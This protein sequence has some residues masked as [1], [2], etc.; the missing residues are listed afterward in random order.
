MRNLWAGMKRLFAPGGIVR[1]EHPRNPSDRWLLSLFGAADTAAG[2]LVREDNALGLSAVYACLK[3]LAENV[4]SLPLILYRKTGDR[5]KERAADEPLYA[6]L[7]DA[8]NPEMT[9]MNFR[10]ALMYHCAFRGNGYAMVERDQLMRVK[11]LWPLS[12]DRV[13]PYR[14]A[15]K[16]L[17]YEVS[18]SSGE[19]VDL[20]PEFMLHVRT[21]SKDGLTGIAPIDALREPLAAGIAMQEY[22]ARFFSNDARASVVLEHPGQLSDDAHKRLKDSWEASHKGV[23]KAH[24]IG[25][26]EEGMKAAQISLKPEESQFFESRKF[27]VSEIARIWNIPPHLLGE[28]DKGMSYASVEQMNLSFVV[29]TLRPWLVRWEQAIKSQL[30]LGAGPLYAE[31]LVDGLLRGDI[32]TRY[33]A[34]QIGRLNG[35]LSANDIRAMENQDPLPEG[36]GGDD[37]LMPLNMAPAGKAQ[38]AS[39]GL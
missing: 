7:H 4:G 19:K 6:I 27:S 16:S 9:S 12:Y 15:D 24:S 8:P 35:W 28:M 30:L 2:V 14:A 38:P 22:G 32:K 36:Q 37:Y 31:F 25:I 10:E 13:R 34:Y 11:A 3:I 17:R 21:M 18:S 39:G 23:Q 20:A 1:R 33:E 5:S 26:L 29:H